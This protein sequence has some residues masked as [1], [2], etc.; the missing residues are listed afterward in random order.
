MSAKRK[1]Q[2]DPPI[3]FVRCPECGWEQSDM[4]NAVRCEEC[5]YGP[6]P[7]AAQRQET[8]PR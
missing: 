1:R 4:G 3:E 2:P 6:M 5:G 7:T 8:R